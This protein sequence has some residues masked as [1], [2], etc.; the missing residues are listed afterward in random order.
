MS[1]SLR[2]LLFFDVG[3]TACTAKFCV[4]R[5]RTL[6]ET[7][8]KG[9][10]PNNPCKLP[11]GARKFWTPFADKQWKFCD[12]KLDFRFSTELSRPARIFFVCSF[13]D[14]AKIVKVCDFRSLVM[15]SRELPPPPKTRTDCASA[16]PLHSYA[17]IDRASVP[18]MLAVQSPRP[19]CTY[20]E[21]GS[22][23]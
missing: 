16:A 2:V 21:H 1:R 6:W 11:R 15:S 9:V 7:N 3:D 10:I 17:V 8:V 19:W 12:T 5:C 23:L 22:M 4:F 14:N 13:Q 18:C 20:N